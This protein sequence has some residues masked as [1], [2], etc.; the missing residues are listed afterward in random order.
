MI[1]FRGGRYII[2]RREKSG[3][4]SVGR[5]EKKKCWEQGDY[6]DKVILWLFFNLRHDKAAWGDRENG[7][8]CNS[9]RS[10]GTPLVG[11]NQ[12]TL[13]HLRLPGLKLGDDS[14]NTQLLH[15]VVKEV[16]CPSELRSN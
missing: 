5:R 13:T 15:L 1:S 14:R 9:L 4:E 3:R 10:P 16:L 6:N 2:G 8:H 7:V 12:E 11:L